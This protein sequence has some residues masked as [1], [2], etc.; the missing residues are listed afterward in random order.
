MSLKDLKYKLESLERVDFAPEV[1]AAKKLVLE[2]RKPEIDKIKAEIEKLR[3][4]KSPPKPRIPENCPDNIIKACENYWAGTEELAKYRIHVWNSMAVW[5]SWGS[6]GYSTNGG[7]VK[8][9]PC[10]FL[11]SLIN[12][13]NKNH[14]G[15]KRAEVLHTI[16]VGDRNGKKVTEKELLQILHEKT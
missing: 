3:G 8:V 11:I 15:G 13:N 5:T 12:F 6:G 14:M 4:K 1:L 2:K 16:D 7:Y 10:Y 9:A